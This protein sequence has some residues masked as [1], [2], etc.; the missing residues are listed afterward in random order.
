[1]KSFF[2]KTKVQIWGTKNSW[3]L[4]PMTGK[5]GPGKLC[6]ILLEIQGTAKNGY[7]LVMSPDGYFSADNWYVNIEDAIENAK[8]LFGIKKKDWKNKS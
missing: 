5:S 8:E 3:S 4:S 2:C 6:N 7:H 1:M